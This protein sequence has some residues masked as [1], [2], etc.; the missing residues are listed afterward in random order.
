MQQSHLNAAELVYESLKKLNYRVDHRQIDI[1]VS[2]AEQ[3][4]VFRIVVE[5][6][7]SVIMDKLK[8]PEL[9]QQLGYEDGERW[10]EEMR[11]WEQNGEPYVIS[12]MSYVLACKDN[13]A[14][15]SPY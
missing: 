8:K 13:L 11:D 12:N 5:K 3:R 15:P 10:I 1:R 7:V 6:G 4:G 2:T 14:I 9:I